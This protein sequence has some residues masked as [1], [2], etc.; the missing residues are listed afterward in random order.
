[1]LTNIKTISKTANAI[2]I[3]GS[4]FSTIPAWSQ[5]VNVETANRARA[6]QDLQ[7]VESRNASEWQWQIEQKPQI[8]ADMDRKQP[9][10]EKNVFEAVLPSDVYNFVFPKDAE[11][12]E[13][14]WRR[15]NQG[16]V[17]EPGRVRFEVPVLSE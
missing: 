3:L 8:P 7:K 12:R 16:D 13:Q 15:V 11:Y 9:Y 6:I 10:R 5:E 17:E 4:I 1:M 14:D 2:L